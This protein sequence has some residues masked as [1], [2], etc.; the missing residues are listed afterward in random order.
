MIAGRHRSRNVGR[1]W[2]A[3]S[4]IVAIGLATTYGV[5]DQGPLVVDWRQSL[6]TTFDIQ[7]ARWAMCPDDSLAFWSPDGDTIEFDP[8]GVSKLREMGQLFEKLD[9]LSCGDDGRV[10]V[11]G[12]TAGSGHSSLAILERST[13]GYEL[14]ERAELDVAVTALAAARSGIVVAGRREGNGYP[15]HR[16]GATGRTIRSFG[17][18][19]WP[20]NDALLRGTLF[21]HS[22]RETIAF[23]PT[24]LP[25]IQVYDTDG[26]RIAVKGLGP[27]RPALSEG[28][29]R[30]TTGLFQFAASQRG[31]EFAVGAA[32]L[33]DNGI[34]VQHV[35]K[36]HTDLGRTAII[37]TFL[38]SHLDDLLHVADGGWGRLLAA[39]SQGA[40]YFL[41]GRRLTRAWVTQ[42]HEPKDTQRVDRAST[43]RFPRSVNA[44]NPRFSPPDG[45]S[46]P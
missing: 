26:R 12:S 10:Y 14:S 3:F 35:S 30:R 41:K 23:V 16:I 33:P 43:S 8:K 5:A 28:V 2:P 29:R 45:R 20:H 6:P 4:Y 24:W 1:K 37:L 46:T 21:W 15:L 40:M 38:D 11:A 22:N 31:E 17:E 18:R 13:R 42:S 7:D 36:W 44:S 34:V 9:A 39:D 25:E 19:G 32:P 27:A